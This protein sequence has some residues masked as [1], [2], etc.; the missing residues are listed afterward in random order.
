MPFPNVPA[1]LTEKMDRCVSKVQSQGAISKPQAIATCF[2][3]VVKE[4]AEENDGTLADL[5]VPAMAE[6]AASYAENDILLK[7]FQERPTLATTIETAFNGQV[8]KLIETG[9]MH[10][11]QRDSFAGDLREHLLTIAADT[12]TQ[13]AA[14]EADPP[15][16]QVEKEEP[17]TTGNA[18]S[19]RREK[20]AAE[21]AEIA[22]KTHSAPAEV[23]VWEPFG[24]AESWA[25][26]DAYFEAEDQRDAVRVSTFEFENLQTNVLNNPDLSLDEKASK[27][28]A[29]ADGLVARTEE[30]QEKEEDAEEKPQDGWIEKIRSTLKQG[31]P[32]KTVDGNRLLASD[33]ASV[34]DASKPGTW[35]L[36]LATTSGTPDAGRIRDA[37]TAMQPGGFRGNRV[38]LTASKTSV[39][40][41]ISG[42]INRLKAGSDVKKRLRGRLANV[43][44][45]ENSGFRVF[46]DAENNWRWFGWATNK[47]RDRDSHADPVNGGEILTEAAHKEFIGWV[48]KNPSRRMPALWPWHT[49]ELAHDMKADWLDYADGFVCV[50]G[51]LN[52]EEAKALSRVAKEF[53]LGMSHGFYALE[54]DE[55]HGHILK[56]RTFE[57][58]YL[59]LENAANPWTDF[60]TIEK[61]VDAMGFSDSKRAM[62]SLL[63]G[64]EFAEEVEQ[65]TEA[66]AEMLD[67]AGIDN[68]ETGDDP[69]EEAAEE[70]TPAEEAEAEDEPEAAEEEAA[71]ETEAEPE[72]EEKDVELSD[73]EVV[74]A[75]G[76]MTDMLINLSDKVEALAASD[77]EK[78]VEKVEHTPRASLAELIAQRASK[79]DQTVVDG[80][81]KLGKDGP[82]EAEPNEEVY[83]G[84]GVVDQLMKM[85]QAKAQV[86]Q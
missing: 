20:R 29:L 86:R 6:L 15:A 23:S 32:S 25:D 45:A 79:S 36:P 17:M 7:D 71:P 67:A 11:G 68:K 43:K 26:L 1:H 3:S 73:G 75:F 52:N 39:V 74:E 84:I 31:K 8:D 16:E 50:S 46:K 13:P 24:G 54:R 51:P 55:E 57:V 63:A 44:A 80:R 21:R 9:A 47:W 77:Q 64:E 30:L 33:F 40:R 59:P 2:N 56:Y 65:E 18:R 60:V 53:D 10:S 61:E 78:I 49:K 72:S 62:L 58:S 34:G 19:R 22:E 85:N 42:A 35:K 66:K 5:F 38:K 37:I 70:A 28:A 82:E 4:L 48:D 81:T 83:A 14:V 41:R 12:K 69:A 76:L 27:I